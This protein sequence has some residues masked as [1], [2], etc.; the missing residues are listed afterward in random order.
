MFKTDVC[1][2]VTL[3]ETLIH[4]NGTVLFELASLKPQY[5]TLRAEFVCIFSL[6]LE[7]TNEKTHKCEV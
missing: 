4:L 2:G 3:G 7:E 5:E 1:T 6:F